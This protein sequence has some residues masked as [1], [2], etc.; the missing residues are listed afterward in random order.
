MNSLNFCLDG[1]SY[2]LSTILTYSASAPRIKLHT[3]HFQFVPPPPQKNT[4]KSNVYMKQ[5]PNSG[6]KNIMVF[7]A[8]TN[9]GWL[10][11]HTAKLCSKKAW[12][13]SKN[14]EFEPL[15]CEFRVP[16]IVGSAVFNK[17]QWPVNFASYLK[18]TDHLLFFEY[19]PHLNRV[20]MYWHRIKKPKFNDVCALYKHSNFCSRMLEMHSKRPR[21]HASIFLLHLLQSLC[22]LLKILLKAL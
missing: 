13:E 18:W 5:H 19:Y 20:L 16:I 7:S 12:R 1:A 11:F 3:L 14:F 22:H 17:S 9:R 4:R 10:D 8:L 6:F 15:E 21:F 2:F